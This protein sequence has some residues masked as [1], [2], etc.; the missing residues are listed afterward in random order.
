MTLAT[1]CQRVDRTEVAA[2]SLHTATSSS[3]TIVVPNAADILIKRSTISRAIVGVASRGDPLWDRGAFC[4]K[5]IGYISSSVTCVP[6]K[7][8]TAI[9]HDACAS[10]TSS[11]QTL[12]RA[13]GS[14]LSRSQGSGRYVRSVCA[15]MSASV[16][17]TGLS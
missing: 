14:L 16:N 6:L 3:L 2:V 5:S 4:C 15:L 17:Q 13:G 1:G 9:T 7:V 10:Q 8:G 11:P 12:H